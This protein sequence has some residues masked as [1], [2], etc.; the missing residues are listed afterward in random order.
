[1]SSNFAT[2]TSLT[3]SPSPR[4]STKHFRPGSL[5][6]KAKTIGKPPPGAKPPASSKPNP[7]PTTTTT[8]SK[9]PTP[10]SPDLIIRA[11][12]SRN[13]SLIAA[14]AQQRPLQCPFSGGFHPPPLYRLRALGALCVRIRVVL[15]PIFH[16][17]F[18]NFYLM[19]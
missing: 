10:S 13:L 16:F 8:T 14:F 7:L 17:C 1:A 3:S 11:N 6:K 19:G 2:C 18:C 15:A 4:I 12:Q 9:A 5:R